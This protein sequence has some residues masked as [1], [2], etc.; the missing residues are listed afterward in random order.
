MNGSVVRKAFLV[1]AAV[2]PLCAAT[3]IVAFI[4]YASPDAADHAY[5]HLAV[6]TPVLL[7]AMVV[8]WSWK[9]GSSPH[10]EKWRVL[11]VLGLP[12][13]GGGQLRPAAGEC[14]GVWLQ[15]R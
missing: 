4:R 15:R 7:L 6:G 3:I 10:P 2:L 12:I 8:G 13:A 9:P 5:S 14:R 11:L 1:V